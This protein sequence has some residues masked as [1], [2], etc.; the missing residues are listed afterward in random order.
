MQKAAKNFLMNLSTYKIELNIILSMIY[1][2]KPRYVGSHIVISGNT[3]RKN[4]KKNNAKNK[5]IK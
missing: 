4:N 5:K 1:W 2:T 3:T